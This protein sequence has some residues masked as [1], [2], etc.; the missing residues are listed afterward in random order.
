MCRFTVYLGRSKQRMSDVLIDPE[1]SLVKQSYHPAENGSRVHGD[2]SG[3]AWYVHELS[4]EPARYRSVQPAWNDI[5]LLEI[6]SKTQS[7]CFMGHVRA[8]T[9]G[10]VSIS[11]CHPFVFKQYAFVHNGTIREFGLIK[12]ALLDMLDDDLF[13]AIKGNSDSE[14]LLSLVMH[15]LR[16][17]L[18]LSKSVL[19]AIQW[20]VS[21]QKTGAAFSRINVALTDGRAL[22]ATRFVSKGEA[23]LPLYYGF[24]RDSH[25]EHQS[26][27][28]SSEQIDGILI[29]WHELPE[30][31]YLSVDHRTLAIKV[32]PIAITDD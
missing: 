16:R 24:Q 15:M 5:N 9:I 26:I 19:T 20:V 1:N 8:A 18:T 2:G 4:A 6:A 30:N 7:S 17:G 31:H 32:R 23:S 25:G 12:R 29:P 13:L 3:L 28:V 27:I 11:N 22:M 14:C 10:E 21:Q